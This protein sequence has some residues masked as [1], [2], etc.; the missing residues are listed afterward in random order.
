MNPQNEARLRK[1]IAATCEATLSTS[2]YVTP[3]DGLLG[4]GWLTPDNVTRWQRGQVP[5]LERVVTASLPKISTAMRLFRGPKKLR[6]VRDC[7]RK[8]WPLTGQ[9]WLRA[10]LTSLASLAR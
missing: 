5:Y 3:V 7:A 6:P 4:T 1:K 8:E 10:R 2:G 9:F